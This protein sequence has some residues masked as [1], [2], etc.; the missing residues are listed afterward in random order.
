MLTKL[1]AK[2]CVNQS[3]SGRKVCDDLSVANST[4]NAIGK[5]CRE[6]GKTYT[7][8]DGTTE[9]A[10]EDVNPDIILILLGIND[11]HADK[12]TTDMSF[13]STPI[14]NPTSFTVSYEHLLKVTGQAYLTANIYCLTPTF[15]NFKYDFPKPNGADCKLFDYRKNIEDV[16]K[17]YEC[18]VIHLDRLGVHGGNMAEF[19]DDRLHPNAQYMTMIANQCYNEMMASNCL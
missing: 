4:V 9:I 18:N 17:E 6:E 1:G 2:L 12:P 7:N 11:W 10:T 5:L 13:S 14:L 8:L 16:A 19:S 15:S 3:W